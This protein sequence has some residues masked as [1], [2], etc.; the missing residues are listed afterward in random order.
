MSGRARGW[1]SDCGRHRAGR[2][3][4]DVSQNSGS[5]QTV[6]LC[7]ECDRALKAKHAGLRAADRGR[8]RRV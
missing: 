2:I 3:I 8:A 5:G 7:D 1:C 6:I 4:G